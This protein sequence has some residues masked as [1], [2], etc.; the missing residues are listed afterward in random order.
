MAATNEGRSSVAA[1][2]TWLLPAKVT[3]PTSICV[4]KSF[5]NSLAASCAATRRVGLT[6]L[7]RML[8]DTSM[9]S[10]MVERAQGRGIDATGRAAASRSNA[11]ASH[12]SAGGR[13]RRQLR[14]CAAACTTLKLL[15][16]S[17]SLPRRRSSHA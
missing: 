5:K 12:N 6:S 4:G 14:P 11:Q 2:A 3:R 7:T 10:K 15:K 17:A 8:S 9:V 13:C 1:C 16:R